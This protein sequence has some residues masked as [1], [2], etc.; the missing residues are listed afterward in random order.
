MEERG[1][2]VRAVGERGEV[3]RWAAGRAIFQHASNKSSLPSYSPKFLLPHSE[4]GCVIC[5]R[6]LPW[7][8]AAS[9]CAPQHGKTEGTRSFLLG[10]SE[11]PPGMGGTPVRVRGRSTCAPSHP[12]QNPR[13]SWEKPLPPSP[14]CEARPRG[15]NRAYNYYYFYVCEYKGARP[16][17]VAR[18]HLRPAWRREEGQPRSC[19]R[20]CHRGAKPAAARGR[21]PSSETGETER[22][23]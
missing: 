22:I 10:A 11:E 23:K 1:R 20:R 17:A 2:G 15:D 18:V 4:Q 9:P 12:G 16:A 7:L 6:A 19:L 13:R 5:Q 21:G 8:P 14:G 3:I